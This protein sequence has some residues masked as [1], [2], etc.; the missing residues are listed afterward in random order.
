MLTN[1]R[2]LEKNPII[3]QSTEQKHTNIDMPYYI[4][5]TAI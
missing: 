4:F 5:C 1:I 2:K 3:I